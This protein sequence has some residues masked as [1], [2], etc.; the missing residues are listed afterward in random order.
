MR[1]M[2]GDEAVGGKLDLGGSL[3]LDESLVRVAVQKKKKNLRK[4]KKKLLK[5][6]RGLTV[7]IRCE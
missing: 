5:R 3:D 7:L 2:R 1:E 6:S 4:R